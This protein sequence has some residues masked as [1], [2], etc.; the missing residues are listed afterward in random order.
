MHCLTCSF[1]VNIWRKGLYP[2]LSIMIY[3]VSTLIIRTY[4]RLA[5]W[6]KFS[7]DNILQ[8]FSYFSQTVSICMKMKLLFSRKNK[9]NIINLLICIVGVTAQLTLVRSTGFDILCKLS[10]MVTVCMKLHFAKIGKSCFLGKEKCKFVVWLCWSL[11]AQ[12]TLLRSCQ[13]SHLP[14]VLLTSLGKTF[15]A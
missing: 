1:A 4:E 7:A 5:G 11:M 15:F 10:A 3:T 14:T 9:K 6:V 12:S 2:A 8:Y 13:A